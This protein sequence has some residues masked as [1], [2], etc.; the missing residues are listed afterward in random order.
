MIALKEQIQLHS[1]NFDKFISE[2]EIPV[3]VDF[4]APW[5]GPCRILGPVLNEIAI[6]YADKVIIAKVNVDEN[7]DLSRRFQVKGIPV[8]KGFKNGI[9][10]HET[11]GA[12]PKEHWIDVIENEL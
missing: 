10:V 11:V 3:L 5:C 8:V 9:Q 12:Y 4:W 1:Q 2:S 6:D 7:P